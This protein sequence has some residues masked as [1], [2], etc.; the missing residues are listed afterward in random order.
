MDRAYYGGPG[1]APARLR[2]G[3]RQDSV[4]S[5]GERA[6]RTAKPAGAM[7]SQRSQ[8]RTLNSLAPCGG[9]PGTTTIGWQHLSPPGGFGDQDPN[10]YLSIAKTKT[11]GT[12]QL[13]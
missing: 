1:D 4:E 9:A 2:P 3:A 7:N 6:T 8:R 13:L 10:D 5:P 12:R 11:L